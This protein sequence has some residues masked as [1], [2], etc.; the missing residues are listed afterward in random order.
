M[1]RSP[2]LTNVSSQLL[3]LLPL[4]SFLGGLPFLTKN[5]FIAFGI[6]SP[7]RDGATV[8]SCSTFSNP[9]VFFAKSQSAG[10]NS[11]TSSKFEA[12]LASWII[13]PN[14]TLFF[15]SSSSFL[16][17]VVP[18]EEE[19]EEELLLKSKSSRKHRSLLSSNTSTCR[20]PF[21]FASLYASSFACVYHRSCWEEDSE[22]WTLTKSPEC[23]CLERERERERKFS[24]FP[25]E[26][27]KQTKKNKPSS[28]KRTNSKASSSRQFPIRTAELEYVLLL[29]VVVSVVVVVIFYVCFLCYCSF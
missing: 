28:F 22:S 23:C 9:V 2:N 10:Y 14:S 3:L 18:K 13:D 19:E 25:Y 11:I 29:N 6:A 4:T 12:P 21:F 20:V 1:I 5:V 27:T 16:V 17:V 26:Y 8:H 7:S 24:K 15:S